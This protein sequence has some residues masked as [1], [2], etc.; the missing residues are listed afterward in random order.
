MITHD[1]DELISLLQELKAQGYKQIAVFDDDYNYCP[2]ELEHETL[3][4]AE[5]EEFPQFK[6]KAI[7][8]IN[9]YC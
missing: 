6:Q 8:I 4:E 5:L 9:P 2:V 7:V 1:I 3:T